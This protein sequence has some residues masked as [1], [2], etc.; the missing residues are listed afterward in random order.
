MNF[1]PIGL[2]WTPEQMIHIMDIDEDAVV[3]ARYVDAIIPK[4]MRR[5]FTTNIDPSG[6]WLDED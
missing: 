3:K 6:M 4:G 2:D 1:G 5:I